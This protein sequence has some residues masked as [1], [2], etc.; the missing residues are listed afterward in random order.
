MFE[1]TRMLPPNADQSRWCGY[2]VQFIEMV[3]RQQ[4]IKTIGGACD[5]QAD[6]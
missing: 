2:K 6:R 1:I 5:S 3:N 4:R